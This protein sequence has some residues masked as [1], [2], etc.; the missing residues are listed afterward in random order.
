MEGRFHEPVTL[1]VQVF[2]EFCSDGFLAQLMWDHV[3]SCGMAVSYVIWVRV[4]CIASTDFTL[5]IVEC[6]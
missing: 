4:L 2:I 6:A 3:I 1:I 5:N